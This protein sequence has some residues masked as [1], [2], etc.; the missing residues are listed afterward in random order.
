MKNK[1]IIAAKRICRDLS[2][3]FKKNL[4]FTTNL[5]FFLTFNV[6]QNE[7]KFYMHIITAGYNVKLNQFSKTD[8]S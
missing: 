8:K 1:I 5:L 2:K 6:K 7:L 3:S 4:Y